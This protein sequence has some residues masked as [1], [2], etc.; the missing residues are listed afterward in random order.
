MLKVGLLGFG[1]MGR[2]HFDNYVRLMEEG[3]GVQLQAICDVRM[4]ELKNAKASGNMATEKEVYD[5]SDYRLYSRLEDMLEQEQ[6]DIVD[7]CLQTYLHADLTCM[8]LEKGYHVLCEKP[9]AGSSDEGWRMVQAA[10]RSGKQL[11]IGQC[12]RFWPE[13][14]YLKACV[15]DGRYG[16]ALA[17]QFYRGSESPTGWFL[18]GDLS[19]GCILDMHIHDAD[20]IHWLFGKPDAVTTQALNVMP[21]SG[22]DIVSTHYSYPDGKV[23]HGHADWTLQGEHGFFM[24]YRVNFERATLVFDQNVLTVYPAE[25]PRFQPDLSPDAGYYREIKY[26]LDCVANGESTIVC[27]PD[28]AV[29]SLEIIEAEIRSAK[30]NGRAVAVA[31]NRYTKS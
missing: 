7:V 12:L 10:K 29:G 8:L 31:H 28:S 14:E 25:A 2:M 27:T 11:M 9:V 21:G 20:M 26:F 22:Y 3:A 17:G 15:E 6:L 1:F 30:E 18:D 23:I 4:D 13:Y 16:K 5:L 19:G 24:G